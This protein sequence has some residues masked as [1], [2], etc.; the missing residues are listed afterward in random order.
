VRLPFEGAIFISLISMYSDEITSILVLPLFG[1]I[2][3]VVNLGRSGV[4]SINIL[5]VSGDFT[6]E[7]IPLGVLTFSNS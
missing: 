7:A 4:P 1:I 2:I 3:E 6:I 5:D